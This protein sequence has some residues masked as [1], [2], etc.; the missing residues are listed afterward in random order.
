[1]L[2]LDEIGETSVRMQAKLLRTIQERVI[3][4]LGCEEPILVNLRIVYATNRDLKKMVERGEFREDLYF[5]INTV[6]VHIPPLRE[7]KE[8]IYWLSHQILDKYFREYNKK[9]ILHPITMSYLK[10]RR[11]PG[12]LRELS[13]AIERACILSTQPLLDLNA[14]KELP[15]DQQDTCCD[16]KLKDSMEKYERNYLIE[17]L[18]RHQWRITKTASSLGISR[19]S[20]WQKMK[21]YEIS[22]TELL[23][24][25]SGL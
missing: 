12:N 18:T 25:S 22:K 24:N 17:K 5:R 13:N 11:W 4:R 8:D 23:N 21:R 10:K 2:F 14:F 3:H 19:K 1:V 15:A 6:H 16:F 7:R 9:R 20:L